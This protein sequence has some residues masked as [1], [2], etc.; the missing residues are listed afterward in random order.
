MYIEQRTHSEILKYNLKVKSTYDKV[1]RQANENKKGKGR[2]KK[3]KDEGERARP[4]VTG[5]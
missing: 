3:Q 1:K 4:N 5:P 2:W